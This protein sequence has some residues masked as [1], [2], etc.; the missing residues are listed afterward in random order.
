MWELVL[1]LTPGGQDGEHAELMS[2]L[3]VTTG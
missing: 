1:M 2:V 3:H